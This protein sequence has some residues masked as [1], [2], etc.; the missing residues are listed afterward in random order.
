MFINRIWATTLP[1]RNCSEIIRITKVLIYFIP[2]TKTINN[3][4]IGGT[5]LQSEGFPDAAIDN[6]QVL[7]V[8]AATPGIDHRRARIITHARSPQQVARAVQNGA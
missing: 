6:E 2:I 5:I 1:K 8:V 7:D 3:N 4:V